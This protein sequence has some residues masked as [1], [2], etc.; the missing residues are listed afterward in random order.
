MMNRNCVVSRS[1]GDGL[2]DSCK[3]KS[4]KAK[5]SEVKKQ[6]A[7]NAKQKV[8]YFG[9]AALLPPPHQADRKEKKK[10]QKGNLMARRS[11]VRERCGEYTVQT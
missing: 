4:S 2:L 5:S 8:F 10:I 7:N 11:C 6:D 3:A 9:E 1:V